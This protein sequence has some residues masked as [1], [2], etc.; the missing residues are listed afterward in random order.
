MVNRQMCLQ[1]DAS[2]ARGSVQSST[3]RAYACLQRFSLR[4]DMKPLPQAP[5]DWTG[6]IGHTAQH[7]WL[8]IRRDGAFVGGHVDS[9]VVAWGELGSPPR[10]WDARQGRLVTLASGVESNEQLA[11]S[12]DGRTLAVSGMSGT[13]V[14]EAAHRRV[15]ASLDT[16]DASALALDPSG[17][18][19]AFF[20]A[21]GLGIST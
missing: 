2:T 3:R 1:L 19:L 13:H 10:A 8:A 7:D 17:R 9:R 15:E 18:R 4:T 16:T 6:H 5:V 12:R 21:K 11:F 14:V 20:D